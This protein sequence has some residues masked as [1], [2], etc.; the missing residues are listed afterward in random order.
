MILK[1]PRKFLTVLHRQDNGD[2]EGITACAGFEL[3]NWRVKKL[4]EHLINWL[5]HFALR[6]NEIEDIGLENP[7]DLIKQAAYRVFKESASKGRGEIG[8]LLLHI[9]AVTEYDARTFVARLFYKM[10]SNDQVTGFD[11]ALVTYSEES[12]EV[13]LWLGEAK[14][15]EDTQDAVKKALASLKG[16]LEEGF[17]EETKILI[18]PKIEPS[19][20]GYDLLQWLFEDGNTLDELISRIVVPVL[21]ASES[22]A[23]SDYDGDNE[24]YNELVIKEFDYISKR[25]GKSAIAREVR[26]VAIYVPL[27]SK[28]TLEA[29]F[30][31][32]LR[33]FQ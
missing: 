13:E 18:G 7:G 25:L 19:S 10:R 26:V 33:V 6:S 24:K 3:G 4:S 30:V 14:F 2:V 22:V 16:H 8:E 12:N 15:Y 32:K 31:K 21:I 11:S 17:L 23:A 9:L 1:T 20:P 27:V 29:E 28:E 5:P